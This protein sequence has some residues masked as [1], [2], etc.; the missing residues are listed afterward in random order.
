MDLSSSWRDV[1]EMKEEIKALSTTPRDLR[2][3]GLTVGSVFLLLGGLALWRHKWTAPWLL[4]PGAV[5]FGFGLVAPKVL[6]PIYIAWMSFAFALGLIVSTVLLTVFFYLV[7][8][9]I[10]LIARV[11]GKDFLSLKMGSGGQ[12][13]WIAREKSVPT[14]AE[15]EQQF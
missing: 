9:P 8:T 5:L 14:A 13:Y 15:Y 3:F 2:K 1:A 10:G 11:A 4:T 12:S 7:I 6:K